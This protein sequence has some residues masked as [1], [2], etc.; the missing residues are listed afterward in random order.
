MTKP[1][2]SCHSKAVRLGVISGM[3]E[4]W[5]QEQAGLPLAAALALQVFRTLPLQM[6][7][8][9]VNSPGADRRRF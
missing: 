8:S 9:S 6:A 4:G 5:G 3:D 2:I 7:L 1:A